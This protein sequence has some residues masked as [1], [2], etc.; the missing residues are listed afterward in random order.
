MEY[1]YT[2]TPEMDAALTAESAN[3]GNTPEELFNIIVTADMGTLVRNYG[4][5]KKNLYDKTDAKD[6]AVI[7]KILDKYKPKKEDPV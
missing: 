3:Q 1:T 4:D 5:K 2:T 6:K 7:D